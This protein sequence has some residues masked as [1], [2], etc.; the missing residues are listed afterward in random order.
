M[1]EGVTDIQIKAFAACSSLEEIVLPSTLKFI[2]SNAFGNTGLKR[3][4][5]PEGV[6]SISSAVF[7]GCRNLKEIVFP[8]SALSS[9]EVLNEMSVNKVYLS[10]R[11]NDWLL[12][13]PRGYTLPASITLY[14]YV[15]DESILSNDGGNYWHY[16]TYG[17][18][19]IW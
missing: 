2:G 18:I 3:I 7:A 9:V 10:G 12:G 4:V 13:I 11:I 1:P 15:E 16:G 5:I 19:V 14:F 17:E 6:T 8:V